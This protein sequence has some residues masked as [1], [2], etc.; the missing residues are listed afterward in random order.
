MRSSAMIPRML[1]TC[2]TGTSKRRYPVAERGVP[3]G[4]ARAGR[5][6]RRGATF[7]EF[8][9]GFL[10]FLT[11]MLALMELGRGMWTY[12]ALAHAARQTG[13]FCAISGSVNPTTLPAIRSVAEGNASGLPGADLGISV[14]WNPQDVTPETNPS[15]AQRGDIVEIRLTYPFRLVTA[16][17]V[18]AGNDIQMSATTRMVV[19]N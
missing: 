1:Q 4:L 14:V 7:V 6:E 19:A 3:G 8:A 18:L 11:A 10:L 15:N 17:L 12:V 2:F 13:R 16:P 5:R 9:L